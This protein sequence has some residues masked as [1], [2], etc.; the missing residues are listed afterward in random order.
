MLAG[1]SALNMSILLPSL[2]QMTLYFGTDY[3]TMQLAVSGYL[4][5]TAI[6]QLFVGP[7][8]DRFG[9]RPLTLWAIALFV[10]ATCGT[11]VATNIVVFMAFRIMQAVV[12]TGMVLSRAI[13]RDMFPQDQAASMIG[14]V[15]MGM[16][17]IPM[18]GPSIGGVFEHFVGWQGS[19]AFLA[20]SGI[21]VWLLIY[22]DQGE[23]GKAGGVSFADQVKDY[24]S[25]LASPRFWGYALCSAFGSGAFFAFLGGAAY[26]GDEVF[27][28]SPILT[29]LAFGAPPAGYVLG[30]FLTARLSVKVGINRMSLLG[31]T[32]SSLGM[33]VSLGLTLLGY[34]HP[35][36]FFGLCT[37]LGLGNGMM[38]P[39]ATAG[40]LSVRPHLAGTASGLG[41]ALMIGGGACLAQLSGYLLAGHSSALPL[42]AVMF[43]SGLFALAAILFVIQREKRLGIA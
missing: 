40:L 39:N 27:H 22:F 36:L 4:A 1:V 10:V 26:V 15:T 5:A 19:F 21:A 38:L 14:Y 18:I 17:L 20:V 28:L 31:N 6:L 13:V 24:P 2:N 23:T 12:A 11:L 25:L 33:G 43:V 29:G 42:Q 7:L 41:S 8:S 9:R 32:V 37:L 16:A 3:A 30:N 35:V 34:E